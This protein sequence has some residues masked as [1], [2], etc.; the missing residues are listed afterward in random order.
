MVA[1]NLLG[2]IPVYAFSVFLALGAC[3]GLAWIARRSHPKLALRMV[4]AGMWALL[5][6]L[7]GSRVGY[8][9]ASWLYFK[10]HILESLQFYRGGLGWPGALAG[11]LLALAV[12][13]AFN[14]F[15]LSGLVDNLLPLLAALSVSAWLGC[16]VTGCAYGI[17]SETWWSLPSSDEWGLVANRW[18]V[19]ILAALLTVGL[20]ALVE[21]LADTAQLEP[22]YRAI[23]SVLGLSL[24][25]LATALLRADPALTWKGLRLEAWAALAYGLL[26]LVSLAAYHIHQTRES[27]Q[28]LENYPA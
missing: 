14:H 15:P 11:G 27:R 26:A 18:P 10:D 1:F 5:G 7:V 6:G 28:K 2:R 12:F 23:L 21:H 25:L 24:I 4:E 9:A 16:W 13:A 20:F 3:L 22:G 17:T 19:Q 8:V